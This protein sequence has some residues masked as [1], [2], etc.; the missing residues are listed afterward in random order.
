VNKFAQK[1]G[2]FAVQLHRG[3]SQEKVALFD[4]QT[5]LQRIAENTDETNRK[6]DCRNAN[7]I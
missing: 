1:K 5:V 2:C 3:N 6:H 7:L 4:G